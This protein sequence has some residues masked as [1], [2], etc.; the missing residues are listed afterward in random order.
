MRRYVSAIAEANSGA[1][2]MRS[3]G[4]NDIA[5]ATPRPSTAVLREFIRA[6]MMAV[7]AADASATANWFEVVRMVVPPGVS[8]PSVAGGGRHG[9]QHRRA[10][11]D[12]HESEDR[13]DGRVGGRLVEQ[14]GHQNHRRRRQHDAAHRNPSRVHGIGDPRGDLESDAAQ[15]RG[16]DEQHAGGRG[17][18]GP[19]RT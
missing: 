17:R 15:E 7:I 8:A 16:E 4:L 9:G 14:R 2:S 1:A 13:D 11:T 3:A 5:P 12:P 10:D 18:I 19:D 6:A